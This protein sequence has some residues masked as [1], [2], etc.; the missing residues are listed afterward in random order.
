MTTTQVRERPILFSDPMI[1]AI[2]DG[3]K[4]QTRRPIVP[5]PPSIEA[6]KALSGIDYGWIAPRKAD[7]PWRVSG[8]VWA[9][10]DLMGQEPELRCPY[11]R[12]GDRLWV[13]EAWAVEA[14][15]DRSRGFSGWPVWYRADG[16]YRWLGNGGV[17]FHTGNSR[18]RWRPSIHMP[19][20]ASRITLEIT[21]VRVERV[22]EI[23]DLSD[24]A[25][26][27]LNAEG[28]D[29]RSTNRVLP[30]GCIN[31]RYEAAEW[32]RALWD[33]INGPRGYGWDANP[34]VWVI[35]FQRVTD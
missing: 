20:W 33:Q 27:D 23:G 10:R 14:G 35:E 30:V 22:Q 13:R 9:V 8:P 19:R 1:R 24:R 15:L 18:G 6:V 12:P 26:H 4:M 2:N 31:E 7:E 34:W 25:W 16:A 5:Q 28:W 29:T 17:G 32:F 21:D 11:G 3:R